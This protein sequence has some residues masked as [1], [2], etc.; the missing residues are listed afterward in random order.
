MQWEDLKKWLSTHLLKL[1]PVTSAVDAHS[2]WHSTHFVWTEADKKT[3]KVVFSFNSFPPPGDHNYCL[4]CQVSMLDTRNNRLKYKK[5][6]RILSL[7]FFV[8]YKIERIWMIFYD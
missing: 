7:F 5:N 2:R 4:S 1:L 6:T 3:D 8:W